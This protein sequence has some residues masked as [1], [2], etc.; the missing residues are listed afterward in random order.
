MLRNYLGP[1]TA[2]F[3]MGETGMHFVEWKLAP[4][5]ELADAIFAGLEKTIGDPRG[6]L[7]GSAGSMLAALHMHSA[8]SEQRWADL[9]A[10]MFSELWE[11]MKSA[12]GGKSW[13]WTHDLYGITTD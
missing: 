12:D 8:T 5:P 4:S 1:A 3:Q 10:R 9:Y 11:Q 13:L 7:W 6:L 2:S